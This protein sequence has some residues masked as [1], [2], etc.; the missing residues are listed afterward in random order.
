MVRSLAVYK[1][2]WLFLPLCASLT[3]ATAQTAPGKLTFA[4]PEHPGRMTLKQG[5]WQTVELSAKANGKVGGERAEEGTQHMLAFLFAAPDKAPLT[6]TTCRDGVLASEHAEASIQTRAAIRS[7]SGVEIAMAVL[8]AP[9]DAR[10]LLRAFVASGDLCGDL[11]FS[12]AD[13]KPG[14]EEA[15][16][17]TMERAKETLLTLTFEP[18]LKPTFDDAFAYAEVESRKHQYASAAAAYR[19]ALAL[20]DQSVD[21]Q[22]FRRVV[23]DQLAMSLGLSGDLSGSR[24]VN[25]AAIKKDP[26][27]P[28]YYYDL[29]C[30]DAEAGNAR[31]A[32]EL[33]QQA[34]DR[35]SHVIPGEPFP[36]PTADDSLQK[37]RGD[38]AFWG[39]AQRIGKEIEPNKQ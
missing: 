37:L 36:N 9:K 14:D 34:Y 13:V 1:E 5:S 31:A 21:P 19:S 32:Q 4:L 18:G 26:D 29:A 24:E 17:Q 8:V 3:T 28:L 12:A 27:Y 38:T 11:A 33:L 2:I 15:Y 30:A 23:T 35:R 39:L 10:M 6:A 25:E 7:A 16:R 22:K 20:I